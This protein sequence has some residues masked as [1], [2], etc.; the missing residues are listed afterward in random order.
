MDSQYSI[1]FEDKIKRVLL[2][3]LF[4]KRK[5]KKWVQGKNEEVPIVVNFT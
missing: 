5:L 3:L 2:P 1:K 4:D